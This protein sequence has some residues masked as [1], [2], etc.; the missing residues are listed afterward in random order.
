MTNPTTR[1][2]PF[3]ID[4][5]LHRREFLSGLLYGLL[6]ASALAVASPSAWAN[7]PK[8]AG[9]FLIFFGERA[10]T[11]L[12][13]SSISEEEKEARFRRLLNEGFDIKTMGKFILG[14]Y[15]R[16]ADEAQRAEFFEVFEEVALQRFLPIFE[17]YSRDSFTVVKVV[18]DDKK[19]E[20]S[21]VL[22]KIKQPKGPKVEVN[23]RVRNRN[24]TYQVLDVAA[25]G[26]S[27]L[28]TLRSEYNTVI[29]NAGG[30]VEAL[31]KLLRKKVAEGA[32]KPDLGAQ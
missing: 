15:W 12:Q 3:T 14:R 6:G 2:S 25:E 26:V 22:S 28:L 13:D 5:F 17:D 32:F 11:E 16:S 4:K 8:D 21:T 1:T 24:E 19:P 7:K 20:I 23:W 18:Q 30:K 29:K 27:M 31:I 9:E 10:L